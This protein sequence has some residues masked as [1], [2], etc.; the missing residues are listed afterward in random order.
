MAKQ[1]KKI[2]VGDRGRKKLIEK[3]EKEGSGN[4]EGW[5]REKLE[6]NTY[7]ESGEVESSGISVGR[8]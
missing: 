1:V 3:G 2:G 7:C 5:K 4:E 6:F 8:V